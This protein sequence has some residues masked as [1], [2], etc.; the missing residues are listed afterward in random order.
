M[1][2][3]PYSITSAMLAGIL[4]NFGVEVFTSL[5]SLPQIVLP[6]IICFLF[7][8]KYLPRYTVVITLLIGLIL[9]FS[10]GKFHLSE[11]QMKIAQ[12]IFTMP[13]FSLEAIIGIGVPLFIV[14]MASQNASGIGVLRADGFKVAASPLITTTG[15]AS[16]A[17]APFGSHAINLAAITAAICTGKEA[18]EDPNK[19]YIAG[20]SCGAFY[21]IFGFFG[22]A[23]AA[24][25]L[26]LPSELI[27][28]IA[29]LALF[30]SLGSSLA[31]SMEGAAKESALITFLVAISGI[32]YFGIGS[33]FWALVAG[34][35][36]HYFLK[37]KI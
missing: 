32:S 15:F 35:I 22:A 28:V 6:M 14:T 30:A 5:E 27:A 16:M 9:A 36:V 23:I 7:F 4:L 26:A 29:G 37:E 31:S 13:T 17:L 8:K 2:R 20:V 12:P 18:H 3:I 25:F 19:R 21:L 33:A 24:V 10:L 34:S 1:N 11:V